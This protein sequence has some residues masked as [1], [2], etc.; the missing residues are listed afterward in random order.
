L[1]GKSASNDILTKEALVLE[2]ERHPFTADFLAKLIK[3]QEVLTR[4]L[5]DGNLD[6]WG[7]DH[8]DEKRAVIHYATILLS[9]LPQV[10]AAAEQIRTAQQQ[11]EARAGRGRGNIHGSDQVT[12]V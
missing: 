11:I 5:V 4:E 7:K 8:S 3:T 12:F 6:K 1:P 2:W 9:Y 10:K